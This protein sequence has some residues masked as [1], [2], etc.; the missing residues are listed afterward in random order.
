MGQGTS[1][2]LNSFSGRILYFPGQILSIL[3][4]LFYI[5]NVTKIYKKE[6]NKAEIITL[7]Q[8]FDQIHIKTAI[9]K[10][11]PQKKFFS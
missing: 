5:K 1:R 8:I 7:L 10:G 3:A 2:D 4:L 9:L 11:K 6:S